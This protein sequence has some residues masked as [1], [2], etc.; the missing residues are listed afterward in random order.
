MQQHV[1]VP[2]HILMTEQEVEELLVR[3][4]IS[5]KQMPSISVKDAALKG[6][7]VKVGDVV[8]IFRNSQTQGKSVFYRVVRE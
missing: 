5:K 1:F 8:K 4:N 2:K 7:T 3:Y 6:I